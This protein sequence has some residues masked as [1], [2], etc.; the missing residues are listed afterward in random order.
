MDEREKRMK[1]EEEIY[2]AYFTSRYITLETS[3]NH[4]I[5]SAINTIKNA[6]NNIYLRNV[7]GMKHKIFISMTYFI[8]LN[9]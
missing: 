8:I 3:D 9:V 2:F 4:Y 1:C 5:I 6:C 7:F